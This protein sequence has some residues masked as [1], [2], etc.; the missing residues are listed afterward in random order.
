MRVVPSQCRPKTPQAKK[1]EK[2]NCS[3]AWD[4]DPARVDELATDIG[5]AAAG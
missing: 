2:S 3:F 5:T 1:Y 4:A